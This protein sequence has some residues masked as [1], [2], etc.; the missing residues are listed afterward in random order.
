M[1][2]SILSA[3]MSKPFN[4]PLGETFQARIGNGI[5]FA[6]QVCHH[7]PISAFY[8]EGKGYKI[9]SSL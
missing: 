5:Y 1:T 6:E 3:E 2:F 8:Y 4:P 7:P 9:Y